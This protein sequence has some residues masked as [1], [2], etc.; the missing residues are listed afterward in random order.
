MKR[1]VGVGAL[2][3]P[4]PV[5]IYLALIICI[6]HAYFLIADGATFWIDAIAYVNLGDAMATQGGMAAFYRDAGAWFYSHLQP[7]VPLLWLV[8]KP[9]PE[10]LQWP[11]LAIVQHGIA[12]WATYYAFVTLDKYW[13]SKAHIL[14]CALV[15]TLPFYQALHNSLMT[16]SIT[17][18]LLMLGFSLWIRLVKGDADTTHLHLKLMMCMLLVG[19]FRGYLV[20]AIFVLAL[21]A[22][23]VRRE[24]VTRHA[25]GYLL[26]GFLA[27]SIF[28]MYRYAVTGEFFYPGGGMNRLMAGLWVNMS[29]SAPVREE[30][31]RSR[32]FDDTDIDKILH[33]GL[34][35]PEAIDL[36][37]AWKAGGM[38]NAEINALAER[39]GVALSKDGADVYHKR[40][41]MGLASSGLVLPYCMTAMPVEVYPGMSPDAMCKH[42][43]GHYKYLAWINAPGHGHFIQAFF[44]SRNAFDAIPG[45]ADSQR[46]IA[47]MLKPY[48]YDAPVPLRDP[49]FLGKLPPDVWVVLAILGAALLLVRE[50]IVG[51][52][53]LIV[54]ASNFAV[55]FF[56]PVGDIR[57]AYAVFPLY[58][59]CMSIALG[60][61]RPGARNL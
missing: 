32:A 15:C 17:S 52:G 51:C 53:I 47:S 54:V 41:L 43:L 30:I 56:F 22:L 46:E 40:L 39:M 55:A 14:L 18:S 20:L 12:G 31:I 6:T 27:I 8:L 3:R 24:L 21:I 19:Q 58:F 11:V 45:W 1:G 29:P 33:D 5:K 38:A 25:A 2:L 37:L 49:L 23:H 44:V 13:P 7:G 42:L 4:F 48:T 61:M 50:R 26:A 35:Y 34:S 16:E 59:L 36:G 10:N 57:Y 28:P 9:F 60:R